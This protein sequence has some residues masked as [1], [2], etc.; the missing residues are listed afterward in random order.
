[1]EGNRNRGQSSSRTIATAE[2]EEEDITA[3]IIGIR[4]SE[5][6]AI[7]HPAPQEE[8][9]RLTLDHRGGT[10]LPLKA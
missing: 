10:R 6:S 5:M 2:E 4:V 3:I 8:G 1:M 7:Y 9:Y